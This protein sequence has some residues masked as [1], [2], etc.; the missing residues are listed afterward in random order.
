M[1]VGP[2]GQKLRGTMAV[3]TILR[4]IETKGRRAGEKKRKT[5]C[6]QAYFF[7]HL[8][9]PP[10]IFKHKNLSAWTLCHFQFPNWWGNIIVSLFALH[11]TPA[12][13]ATFWCTI[14]GNKDKHFIVTF[15]YLNKSLSFTN[16]TW[17]TNTLWF[18]FKPLLQKNPF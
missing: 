6:M 12:M 11:N 15:V 13:Q 10:S 5:G 14:K 1:W 2:L 3:T 17:S 4:A 16:K 9:P 7:S 8:L 18:Q